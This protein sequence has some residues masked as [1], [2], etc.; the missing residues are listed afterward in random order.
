ML[1]D[2]G[3]IEIPRFIIGH[4]MNDDA[5]NIFLRGLVVDEHDPE[6]IARLNAATHARTSMAN[7]RGIGCVSKENHLR[8]VHF[9]PARMVL[10]SLELEELDEREA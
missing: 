9:V 1:H 7:C 2:I 5:M 8:S 4:S 3:K 6:V 10:S